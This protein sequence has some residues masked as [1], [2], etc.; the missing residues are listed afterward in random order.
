[1]TSTD[2][3]SIW[4]EGRPEVKEKSI[5]FYRECD[6]SIVG[7]GI[8]G[9]TTAYLLA[10]SGKSVVVL[11]AGAKFAGGETEFTT[12]HLA[13]ALDDR[14]SSLESVR[15]EEVS[16]IGF[17]AHAKAIDTIESLSRE[18]KIDC[19][20]QRVD[21]YLFLGPDQEASI[22]D[23][24]E[25]AAR[26]AGV[27][28]ERLKSAP[29]R[30][31]RVG[32]CL[33]FPNQAR[34]HPLKYL[35]GIRDAF[36]KLGGEVFVKTPVESVVPGSP[37]KLRTKVGPALVAKSCVVATNSPINDIVAIHTKQ[38]PYLTYAV[39]AEVPPVEAKDDGLFWDTLDPYHYVRFT[40]D[41]HGQDFAV[42]GGGDHKTGQ[43]SQPAEQTWRDLE[44]W[45]RGLIPQLGKVR[46]NWSGQVFETLD[47]LAY[48]GEDPAGQENV[49]VATGDSG[50]GL[51]HGTIAGLLLTDLILGKESPWKDAFSPS[52]KPVKSVKTFLGENLN[53]A[54]QFGDWLTGS[55]VSS[56]DEIKPGEGAVV[57]RGLS[58]LAVY[59]SESGAVK[60]MS[61]TCTH[62]G[63]VVHWNAAAKTWDCPCHGSRFNGEGKVLHGPAVMDL[64][65]VPSDT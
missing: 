11:D 54:A 6:V 41:S 29:S 53:V 18:L 20:F 2:T 36:L 51:T 28:I 24:E 58:K 33:R 4:S 19:D 50:M 13:S 45:A 25:T 26:R 1:M 17:E 48:I 60:E 27:R 61:A 52:R 56:V 12:A 32:D 59:K 55:E 65:L 62:L 8:A 34:F 30:A 21:G 46:Y 40:K 64:E 23:E 37:V 31:I 14:F 44:A 22:L 63:C 42:I 9:L 49:Y 5:D 47:G 39:A 43:P 7:A 15:G 35:T 10:K 16:R 57:R 38:Y 3:D